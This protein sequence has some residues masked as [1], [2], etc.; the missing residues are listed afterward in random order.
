MPFT[1]D[2]KPYVLLPCILYCPDNYNYFMRCK[3]CDRF[4][5]Q[6]GQVPESRVA[7]L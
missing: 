1:R 6:G 4:D 7:E 5:F 3:M 2:V